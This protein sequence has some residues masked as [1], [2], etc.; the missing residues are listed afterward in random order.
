MS[1]AVSTNDSA[2]A[3][4]AVKGGQNVQTGYC[5]SSGD[6]CKVPLLSLIVNRRRHCSR[7][8]VGDHVHF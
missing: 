7:F 2:I 4:V 3:T 6:I 5:I 8:T 1:A